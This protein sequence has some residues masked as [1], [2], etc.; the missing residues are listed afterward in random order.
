MDN[1][2]I[3]FWVFITLLLVITTFNVRENFDSDPVLD[4]MGKS[5]GEVANDTYY[6]AVYLAHQQK[7]AVLRG[8]EKEII[9]GIMR[10]NF[11]RINIGEPKVEIQNIKNF[12]SF[13]DIN[14]DTTE[15]ENFLIDFVD[16]LN[17]KLKNGEKPSRKFIEKIY[18]DYVE[19]FC[20]GIDKDAKIS[21]FIKD[22]IPK[23]S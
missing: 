20:E 22:K 7:C 21:S 17:K 14:I 18:R 16:D 12:L 4:N 19:S 5:A 13:H 8:Y 6:K 3:C 15:I 2:L 23:K 10:S 9:D 11:S 1:R